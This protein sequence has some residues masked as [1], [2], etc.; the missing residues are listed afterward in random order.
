MRTEFDP[1]LFCAVKLK[2]RHGARRY[3][4]ENIIELSWW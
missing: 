4:A 1:E 3:V 2:M